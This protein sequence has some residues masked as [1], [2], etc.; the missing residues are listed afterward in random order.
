MSEAIR[1]TV[2]RYYEGRLNQFGPTPRG[3]DWNSAE[4]QAL[5]FDKLLDLLAGSRRR[6]R[7]PSRSLT[8]AVGMAL[9]L[10]T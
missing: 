7:S 8:S 3:V 6:M 1:Q 9:S 2:G 5:R 10:I 4:S